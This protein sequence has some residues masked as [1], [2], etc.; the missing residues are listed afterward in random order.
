MTFFDLVLQTR[1]SLHAH[2]EPDDFV[3]EFTGVIH[4]EGDDGVSRSV[5]KVHAWRIQAEG[6]AE[7][8]EPL[9]DVCDA[10]SQEMH[11]VHT[12]LYEPDDYTYRDEI[13]G[14]FDL[15][16]WDTLFCIRNGA[17]CDWDCLRRGK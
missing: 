6:A 10:H 13:V 4:A 3:S 7:A 11:E 5:G 8:G 12:L 14:R 16:G 2:G 17:D 9:F 15:A 1:T